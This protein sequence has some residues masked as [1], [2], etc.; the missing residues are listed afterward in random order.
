M[1]KTKKDLL[2][3]K[4]V[5][6]IGAGEKVAL[7][8]VDFSDSNRPKVALEIDFPILPV[9]QVANIEG[10]AGKPIYQMSKWWARRRSSVFRAML[11]A[12]AMKAPEDTLDTAKNIWQ[13]Y[14]ANHQQK[15]ALSHLTVADIFMGGG[16][17]LVEGSR[18]GMQMYGN[19][20]NPVAWLVVKNEMSEVDI[21]DVKKLA[22]HVEAEVKPQIIPYYSCDCPRGHKGKWLKFDS[23]DIPI[24]PL[25]DQARIGHEENPYEEDKSINTFEN[26]T[27]W[28]RQRGYR[29]EVMDEEFDPLT[30]TNEERSYYRYWGPEVIYTFWAKH[31]PCQAMGCDHLTPIM[32]NPVVAVKELSVKTWA[33]F[34]CK[35]GHSFDVEEKEARMAPGEPLIV[36]DT[37]PD[38]VILDSNEFACPGCH[39]KYQMAAFLKQKPSNYKPKNKKVSLSLLVHPQWLKGSKG[40]SECG[41]PYG[42]SVTDD[43]EATIAWNNDRARTL[44][45]I[46]V[47][48]DLPEEITCPE[49]GI[50][51]RTGDDGGTVPKRS[52]FTCQAETCG[53]EQDVLKSIKASGKTGPTAMYAMQ[54]FCPECS[55][56]K[57]IYGGRF[58]SKPNVQLYNRSLMEWC[59]RKSID[60]LNYWPKSTLPFGFMTHKL[61]GG[62]PNHGY[63]HW[64]TMFNERQLLV[65]SQLLKSILGLKIST[66]VV[67]ILLGVFQQYLRNQNMFCFW[68][69]SY[70]KL[71][72][73]MSNNNYHPKANVI[74]NSVFAELGRGN[75]YSC[76]DATINGL[77]WACDPYDI[78]SNDYLQ[79][80]FGIDGLT[81]K[82]SKVF[83][84]DNVQMAKELYC[85]SSTSLSL[86]SNSIDLVIT[87]PPFGD[88]LH[89]SEL[90]DFFYV[91][92]RLALK[93]KYPD[94]FS[95]EYT[96]K[97]LE[98]VSN[99][100]RN[101][102]DPDG[103]YQKIL[104]ECWREAHRILKPGGILAFT[105]HHSQDDPWVAVL[106]SLFD[107]GFY[108]EATYPIRSDETKGEK[109]Q[110]GS[111]K[112]EYDIIHVCRKRIDEP[113]SVSWARMRRQV[114]NDIRQ[115]QG[116]LNNHLES[117]LTESDLQ[118]I[119][120]GKALEYFS[121]H[122][123]KV[124][125][126][127]GRE[128][129]VKEALLGINQLIDD[130]DD[131]QSDAPPIEAEVYTRQFLR[132]FS[133]TINVKRNE[134]Q[135][136]LR[137]TGLAPKDF[138]DKGWCKETNK[139]F[140]MVN[141]FEYAKE[142]KGLYRKN[143]SYDL[144]QTLFLIGACYENSG[145]NVNDTLSND[146]FKPHPA[147]GPLLAWFS[148]NGGTWEMRNAAM[149]ALQIFTSWKARNTQAHAKQLSLFG[150]DE[151]E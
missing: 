19:D 70:D 23:V 98:A 15:G 37:E 126:E 67:D 82:S 83:I 9:N 95:S 102:E 1:T 47:R 4:I 32:T 41:Q 71:V 6:A 111:K 130:E 115:L 39:T 139:V 22:M 57:E 72:P 145:I 114:I 73:H 84:K 5:E 7:E 16:T 18:L 151:E 75:W 131:K 17:T 92:L 117:G 120:R 81:G 137:G 94:Q 125:V 79:N 2:E 24:K 50:R 133:K 65:L 38:F 141:P 129:S 35:C 91:W 66:N 144:D 55:N 134:M 14:Y 26:F 20:L 44:R 147:L 124:Y 86:K 52:T 118:V 40:V 33:S 25:K 60:L 51:V 119:K 29:F 107:A 43:I 110:F 90:S 53:R 136:Y 64:W 59:Y 142:W 77:L 143:M 89:Y 101:P 13:V 54:G 46:E 62:I 121:R 30:L 97:S 87:D 109:G 28:Y 10:N 103:F 122:Y 63:T 135:N 146:N 108:L 58:F 27:N 69:L 88:I 150:I 76:L 34:Q 148:K 123:G 128:F 113:K 96:L 45:L 11:I 105:F 93:D 42:G 74:E 48:G 68:D 149:R 12:A 132:I 140:S 21:N 112:I 116:I 138:E 8:T 106:E 104:T 31:G 56:N 80:T 85:K 49:T 3:A 127:E 61:N 78:V 99:K 36:A 100:A